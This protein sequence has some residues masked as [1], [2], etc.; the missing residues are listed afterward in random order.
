VRELK[1]GVGGITH[2]V[3]ITDM[4]VSG[5]L[6]PA[7][8]S[9]EWFLFHWFV[10]NPLA[11]CAAVLRKVLDRIASGGLTIPAGTRYPKSAMAEA[12]RDAET[13][14]RPGKPLVDLTK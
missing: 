14:G 5:E 13:N 8:L 3:S 9:K 12:L 4:R 6:G 10:A 1:P 7:V 11:D 2:R